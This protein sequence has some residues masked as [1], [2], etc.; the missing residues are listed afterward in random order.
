VSSSGGAPPKGWAPSDG[1]FLD[2][3]PSDHASPRS[4]ASPDGRIRDWPIQGQRT[5]HSTHNMA[6]SKYVAPQGW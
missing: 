2:D 3:T 5:N 6:P 1:A 4:T